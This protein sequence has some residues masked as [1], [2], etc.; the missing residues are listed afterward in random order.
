MLAEVEKDKPKNKFNDAKC[1]SMGRLWFGTQ[2]GTTLPTNIHYD[3][4]F[5]SYDNGQSYSSR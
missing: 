2:G 4:G 3:G 5:Y 1:D